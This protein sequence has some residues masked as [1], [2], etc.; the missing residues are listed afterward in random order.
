MPKGFKMP[1]SPMKGVP[2]SRGFSDQD[3]K[4][5]N[6]SNKSEMKTQSMKNRGS[7]VQMMRNKRMGTPPTK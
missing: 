2:P 3:G 6:I 5:K 1:G 7:M 4:P